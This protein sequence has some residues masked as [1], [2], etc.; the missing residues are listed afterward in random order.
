MV[1]THADA[2]SPEI[3][4]LDPF[5]FFSFSFLYLLF[6]LSVCFRMIIL[7]IANAFV[8]QYY[9]I[10]R[11]SPELVHRFYCDNSSLGRPEA[12]G[13]LCCVTTM[14]VK[15]HLFYCFCQKNFCSVNVD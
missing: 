1:R 5:F 9:Y 13:Q 14:K 7:Q 6:H 8:L 10:F 12:N 2:H 3:V 4:G 15:F 11:Y